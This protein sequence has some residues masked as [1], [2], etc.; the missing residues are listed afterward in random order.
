[1]VETAR[2]NLWCDRWRLT[3]HLAP[4][5]TRG[6]LVVQKTSEHR[7]VKSSNH[8]YEFFGTGEVPWSDFVPFLVTYNLIFSLSK[9]MNFI[10]Q[11]L[12]RQGIQALET[13]GDRL[14]SPQYSRTV[15]IAHTLTWT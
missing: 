14:R 4:V 15:W 2:I 7:L 5:S 9:S 13:E 8:F 12:A 11:N 1:M 10:P 3:H 6:D